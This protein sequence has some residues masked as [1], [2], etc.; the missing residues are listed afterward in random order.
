MALGIEDMD[1]SLPV[2]NHPE[3]WHP[4]ET[5]LSNW[6]HMLQI[7]KVTASP[8]DAENEKY[9]P[10]TWHS[11]SEAQVG[12]TIAAFDQLVESIESRMPAES[13]RLAQEGPLLS[14]ADLDATSIPES[15]FVRGFL[16]RARA[17]RFEF[18]AP[19]LLVP[20]D[21]EAFALDEAFT[22]IN[23]SSEDG[24]VIPPVLLFRAT[25]HT[26]NFDCENK[27]RS[28]N[29][30]CAPIQ[31]RKATIQSQ[32]AC[33]A[34]QFGAQKLIMRRR[35][36]GLCCYFLC[37]GKKKEQRRATGRSLRRERWRICFSMGLS[38]LVASGGALRG[39][40]GYL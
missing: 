15:C 19:G 3:L 40:R 32:R 6:I 17:P 1:F 28:L 36:F 8:D 22:T 39:W 11:Y 29:P 13:L 10:W 7:S 27:Y 2:E 20:H 38:R 31:L 23:S 34:S 9:G 37:G 26:T 25:D 24:V 21:R 12:S 35:A 18:V 16:T 30:F 14:D 5:V 33:I 4:L